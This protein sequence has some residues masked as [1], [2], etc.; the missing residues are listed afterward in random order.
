MTTFA[1]RATAT[2]SR[3]IE[4]YGESVLYHSVVEGTYDE[5]TSSVTNATTSF[6]IYAALASPSR[7]MLAAG[8][9]QHGDAQVM[10]SGSALGSVVPGENDLLEFGGFTW[11]IVGIQTTRVQGMAPL[12]TLIV[13]RP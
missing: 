5:A 12:Y 9:A 8:V 10:I 2:A 6:T 13:R 4:S 1:D 3:L 11:R 7:S